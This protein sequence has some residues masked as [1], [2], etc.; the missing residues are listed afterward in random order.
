M[1]CPACGIVND[2]GRKFCRECGTKLALTCADCG[3]ANTPGDKFCGECGSRLDSAPVTAAENDGRGDPQSERRVVSVLFADLVGFTPMSEQRDPE[4]MRE[5]LSQYFDRCR[6]VI[7]RYGGTVG[8]FI[9]DAV[10]A[11]WGAPV[12]REDDAERAVRAALDLTADIAALDAEL[13]APGLRVRVGVG[14]GEAAV[15]VGAIGEGMVT[16]DLVNTASRIQSVAAQGTVLVDERTARLSEAAIAY[17]DAGEHSLKGKEEAVRLLRPLRVVAARR[18][19]GRT[20]LVEAPFVGRDAELRL[21][22]E[23]LHAT[24]D[25]GKARVVSVIGDAGIGKSRLAW[26]FYKYFDG[27]VE[28]LWWHRGRCLP[29]GEGVAY[30]ALAEMVRMRAGIVEDESPE[31]QQAKLSACVAERITDQDE[32]AW[33][34]PRLAHLLGL[35]DRIAPDQEDLF[36]AWR[37][38]FERMAEEGPAILLFEDL[39]WADA[40]L[41]DFIEYLAEWSRNHPLF[42]VTLARPELLE[43]RPTWGAG[44]RNFHSVVLE[45]LPEHAR[46]ELLDGLV[47]GLPD[48]VQTLVAERAG[49]IPLYAIETVRMLLDRGAVVQDQGG[50]R[51]S[52]SVDALDVPETLQALIAARLDGLAAAERRLLEDASVIGRTFTVQGLLAI[53]GLEEVAAA[54]LLASLVRKEILT[55]E[56]DPRSPERGQYGFLHALVQKVAYDMLARRERKARHLAVA[57]YLETTWEADDIPE[58]IA[59]HYLE[60]Y[61]AAPDTEDAAAIRAQARDRLANAGER[62]ASLAAA[63]DARRYFEQAL[64]L[65]DDAGVRARLSVRAGDTAWI[66]GRAEPAKAHYTQARDLFESGGERHAAARVQAAIAEI[67]WAQAGGLDEALEDMRSA[68]EAL[69]ADEPDEDFAMLAA[70]LGRMLYFAGRA[71]EAAVV[72]EEALRLA[73]GL[74]LPEVLSQALNSKSLVL[75][76]QGR[77]DE[78]GLLLRHALQVALD[79]ELGSAALRAYNNLCVALWNAGRHEDELRA[80]EQGVDLAHR[81]GNRQWEVQLQACQIGPLNMLGRWDEAIAYAEMSVGQDAGGAARL[82]VELSAVIALH[83]HR[84]DLS[85]AKELEAYIPG[86]EGTAVQVRAGALVVR[87]Q[88]L[89]AEGRSEEAIAAA[90]EAIQLALEPA[91]ELEAA[92]ELFAAASALSDIDGLADLLARF[93]KRLPGALPPDVQAHI[94]RFRAGL[95]AARGEADAAESGFKRASAQLRELG[96][97]FWLAVSLLEYGEWLHRVGRADEAETLLEEARE[98]F[99]RLQARPWLERLNALHRPSRETATA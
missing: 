24:A 57:A 36:S 37:R 51:V 5:L 1:T 77:Y 56:T 87:A 32:R 46:R 71:E 82:G 10:M 98:I 75:A 7:E 6:R 48:E 85:A 73:E 93:T 66:A 9:G 90:R 76:G 31:A 11:V 28:E 95:A 65:A 47:P 14:T 74:R 15:V 13:G 41:L 94:A 88:V 16:G 58:V 96:T 12:A 55:V 50:Y 64:E 67:V 89:N 30:W 59:S 42:I 69:S 18:G 61:R 53:S 43:R 62:A 99:G 21:V 34:E 40:A 25:E 3:A 26:E 20:S 80:A 22:K 17:E 72:L 19:E 63:E 60:A 91:S 27:L 70:Q 52:G 86:G 23:L 29:Y 81:L 4:E 35:T 84:G 68:Y 45:P 54:P 44:G 2:T 97:P 78:A 39:Q 49:G 38:F 8:K 92:I 33:I 83:L 79:N